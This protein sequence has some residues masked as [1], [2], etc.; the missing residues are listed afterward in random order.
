MGT[1]YYLKLG[2]RKVHLGK[3]SCGWRFAFHKTDEVYD[4]IS[5]EKFIS[6]GEIVN[7]YGDHISSE[8]MIEII[9]RNKNGKFHPNGDF[10]RG[11]FC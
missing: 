9:D 6:K 3:Q 2:N 4:L 11:D 1:N 10:I 5:F 7:E 8:E